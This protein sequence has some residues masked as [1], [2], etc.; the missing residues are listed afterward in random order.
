MTQYPGDPS[1]PALSAETPEGEAASVTI[2]V[3]DSCRP[4]HEA[5]ATPR[6]GAL[7]A[8]ATASVPRSAGIA[9]KQVTCLGNCERALSAALVREGAW[10]YVFGGLDISAAADLVAGAELFRNSTDGRLPYPGRPQA[11]KGA[12]VARIPPLE[13]AKEIP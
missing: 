2:I 8:R 3:C 12:L 9:V 11:L 4:S 13:L 1:D 5:P 6:P 7:L 10:S